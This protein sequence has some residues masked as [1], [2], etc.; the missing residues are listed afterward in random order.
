MG[1]L[2]CGPRQPDSFLLIL[3]MLSLLV[4]AIR[5]SRGL[6]LVPSLSQ[7]LTDECVSVMLPEEA[8]EHESIT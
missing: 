4:E 7:E 6:F 2:A 1:E 5:Y 3:Q 8:A